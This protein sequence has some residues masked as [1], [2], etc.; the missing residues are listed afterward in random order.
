M[1]IRARSSCP[2]A[3]I[4]PVLS[5]CMQLKAHQPFL[6]GFEIQQQVQ[7]GEQCHVWACPDDGHGTGDGYVP[8]HTSCKPYY[9]YPL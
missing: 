3:T 1:I 9:M 4:I 7:A 8:S 6:V 2:A 5:N